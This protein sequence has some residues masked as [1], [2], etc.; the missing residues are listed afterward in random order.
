M[1]RKYRFIYDEIGGMDMNFYEIAQNRFNE[2]IIRN[3]LR[4]KT[5]EVPAKELI[6]RVASSFTF[7]NLDFLP[8]S[9]S[10]PDILMLVSTTR[11][12]SKSSVYV[13]KKLKTD[14]PIDRVVVAEDGAE[15]YKGP[16]LGYDKYRLGYIGQTVGFG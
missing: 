9:I 4:E 15:L 16:G 14:E 2:Y 8:N 6:I 7:S 12:T 1:D 3:E 11:S 10:F 5:I 13:S